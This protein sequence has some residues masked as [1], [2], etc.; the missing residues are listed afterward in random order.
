MQNVVKDFI[1]K[2]PQ[3]D[4]KAIGEMLYEIGYEVINED[5]SPRS[6]K[7]TYMYYNEA[8]AY[9]LE[10]GACET[11]AFV[12]WEP[13]GNDKAYLVTKYSNDLRKL[14]IEEELFLK[15]GLRNES[16]DLISAGKCKI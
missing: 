11:G 14:L 10:S 4:Q 2:M 6:P 5:G 7:Q 13:V 9:L 1:D 16:P 12:T 15:V 3:E 8:A